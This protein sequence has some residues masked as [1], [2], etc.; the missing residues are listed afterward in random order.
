[1][2]NQMWSNVIKF[3][4]LHFPINDVTSYLSMNNIRNLYDVIFL[5]FLCYT[6]H[7]V[8]YYCSFGNK[9]SRSLK[10]RQT[11]PQ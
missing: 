5:A 11:R 7:Q 3:E 10:A 6:Y 1:M 8:Y 4:F 2:S 9:N